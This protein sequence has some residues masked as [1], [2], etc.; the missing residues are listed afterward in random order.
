MKRPQQKAC[1]PMPSRPDDSATAD[2]LKA[3]RDADLSALEKAYA[4]GA[5]V[6]RSDRDGN[7]ALIWG[8]ARGSIPVL[9]F[10]FSHGAENHA[11]NAVGN[12]ALMQ[13]IAAHHEDAAAFCLKHHFNMAAVNHDGQ[14]AFAMAAARDFTALMDSMAALGADTNAADSKK[15]TPLMLAAAEGRLQALE[16][17]LARDGAAL[18]ARDEEG[19]TALMLACLGGHR[20]AAVL[21]LKSGARVDV[22]DNRGRDMHFY[23]RQWGLEDEVRTAF[24][25]YDV[26]QITEGAR[27]DISLMKPLNVRRR[28]FT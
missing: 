18:E 10:L 19:H 6:N 5:A 3:A 27:R 9:S 20:A 1:V 17:L 22:A 11:E 7:T 21:L 24:A 26:K 12:N 15:R 25:R 8:G 14:T 16:N 2:F 13:A 28:G 4:A 23:A